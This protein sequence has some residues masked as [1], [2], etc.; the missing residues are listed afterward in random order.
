MESELEKRQLGPRRLDQ[1]SSLLT[2]SESSESESDS[3]RAEPE[4]ELY[5]ESNERG[6]RTAFEG[7]HSPR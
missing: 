7:L 3:S 5:E 4:L 2:D 1:E 6:A